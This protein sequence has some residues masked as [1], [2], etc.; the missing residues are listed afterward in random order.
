MRYDENDRES[1]NVDDRRGQGGGGM[2][3]FPGSM[4]GRGGRR[5]RIPFP[6]GRGGRRGGGL[7]LISLLVIGGIMLM[8]GI[9][10]L[11]FLS[12]GGL[13]DMSGMPQMP[14]VDSGPTTRTGNNPFNIPGL[15][16]NQRTTNAP[17]PDDQLASFTKKVLADTE[18]VWGR[19]FKSF[20]QRYREPTLVLFT[21]ATSTACGRGQAAMGPFYCPLDQKIYIDLSFYQE[22]RKR[23]QA[24]GDFAQAYV[25][26]H[27]VG[28]HVQT[29]LGIASKVQQMK[30]RSTKRVAN[31]IQVRMELQADCLSGVWANLNHQLKNRL[32]PGDIEEGLRAASAI[33]DDMIQ[34]R[35]TGRVLQDAFTHGSSEQRVR[36]FRKGYDSGRMQ[37]CDTFSQRQL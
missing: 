36:W 22:L 32:E 9:N 27:E 23:F 2:F 29:L 37:S 28:H 14:R 20:G 33:G 13:P 6:S 31:Q 11:K 25:I 1:S 17:R 34:R 12:G 10:P 18:D 7:S 16:G 15:P 26:A 24:P 35:T 21:G 19:V 3:R 8:L 5:V 30:Q 4:G